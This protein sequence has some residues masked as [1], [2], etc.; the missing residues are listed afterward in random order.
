MTQL[1]YLGFNITPSGNKAKPEYLKSLTE[2]AKSM[3]KCQ[4][5]GFIGACNW[6]HEYVP[7]LAI[8]MAPLTDLLAGKRSIR[9][10]TKAEQAFDDTKSV[11]KNPLVLSRPR[12]DTD[13]RLRSR[14]GSSPVPAGA[15]KR[16]Q[17]NKSRKRKIL[18]DRGEVSL[19]RTR[20]LSNHL[21]HQTF[22]SIPGGPAFHVAH[23]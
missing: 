9:W 20:M 13:R 12:P 18:T 16:S 6:L 14:H 1:E 2:Y 5:Q 4:L 7:N 22:S 23:R 11:F 19:Q 3:T 21:G 10:T 15:R 8:I 17:H